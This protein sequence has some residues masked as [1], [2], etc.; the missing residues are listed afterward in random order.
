MLQIKQKRIVRTIIALNFYLLCGVILLLIGYRYVR[1]QSFLTVGVILLPFVILGN[2][3]FVLLW[4]NHHELKK[5]RK[6]A[7]LHTKMENSLMQALYDDGY[8]VEREIL[9]KKCAVIPRL[10][11]TI[12]PQYDKGVIKIENC[13][14]LDKRLE[15][16]PISSALPDEY[17]L[18]SSYISDDCNY[19]IYEF[20]LYH[21]EQLSFQSSR[22]F[23][24]YSRKDTGDYELFLDSRYKVPIFHAL[25]VGQTGSGKS[26]CLYN[27][28]LQLLSKKCDVDLYIADPKFSGLY[29]LG[30][31]INPE[32]VA[33]SVEEII[34]LLRQFEK[35]MLER[36]RVFAE[37]LVEKL[38]SDYRDFGFSPI[39]LI[40]DEY[41]SFKA[42][43]ARYD[44]K[45]RDSVDEIIGNTIR[46]GRQLGCFC[47]IAQQQTNAN[48]LSTELKE[49]LPFKL[50]LG[51][52]ERQTYITAL[53]VYP[54]VAKRKFECGQ[55]LLV[56]PQ[57]ATPEMP[58]ITS[59][60]RLDF[61]I[62]KAIE[63]L[64]EYKNEG[65]EGQ[66][67]VM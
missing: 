5:G 36:K 29:V 45:T 14:K 59:I 43:L 24:D 46:E 23:F 21:V 38:D 4:M 16:L 54:D 42:S 65:K 49:N 50:I 13:I 2:L 31:A 3:V 28:V 35:K 1:I 34:A 17:I 61:D 11:I 30:R 53:G 57:I 22:D 19:Y 44:K 40:I 41:S 47:F 55:G 62:L 33:S 48:N 9:F 7:K 63:H 25:I 6:Y 26:Y 51:M 8:Y 39:C 32:K 66:A 27:F 52:A 10:E 64:E 58:A 60:A 67:G 15:E 20:E 12:S 56:Y 37:C 18:S